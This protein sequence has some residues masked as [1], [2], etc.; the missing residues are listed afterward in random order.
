[1]ICTVWSRKPINFW[2][3]AK[4]YT[5]LSAAVR[6]TSRICMSH[7]F[8]PFI[9]DNYEAEGHSMKVMRL[10]AIYISCYEMKQSA[11]RN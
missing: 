7:L 11:T 3:G 5:E 8:S 1:M 6:V 9:C 10:M 2:Y 4:C